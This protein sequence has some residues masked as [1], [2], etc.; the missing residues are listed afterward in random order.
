MNKNTVSWPLVYERNLWYLSKQGLVM[1]PQ[2]AGLAFSFGGTLAM[3]LSLKMMAELT[4]STQ[5]TDSTQPLMGCCWSWLFAAFQATGPGNYI[6][7][8]Q[9]H[10]LPWHTSRP[11]LLLTRNY[12]PP[13]TLTQTHSPHSCPIIEDPIPIYSPQP[14]L[15]SFQRTPL[16]KGIFISSLQLGLLPSRLFTRGIDR[17]FLTLRSPSGTHLLWNSVQATGR[18]LKPTTGIFL[19]LAPSCLHYLTL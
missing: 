10:K 9:F 6:L 4:A 18:S 5:T 15:H 12:P 8:S 14:S 1:S 7:V 3:A 13:Y 17:S 11:T 19:T 2:S 16:N